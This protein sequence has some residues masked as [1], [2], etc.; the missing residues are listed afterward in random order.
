MDTAVDL[1]RAGGFC[2]PFAPLG[3]PHDPALLVAR[4]APMLP[5]GGVDARGHRDERTGGAVLGEGRGDHLRR[6]E[7]VIAEEDHHVVD[8]RI[9]ERQGHC[10]GVPRAKL[11]T[12]H[13]KLEV[14]GSVVRHRRATARHCAG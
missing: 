10:R 7:R 11:L 14:R 4:D 6:V 12:L 3:D 13:D 2:A 1:L 9:E 5:A 8:R